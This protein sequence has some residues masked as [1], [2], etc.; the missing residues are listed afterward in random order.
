M[1]KMKTYEARNGE[2]LAH[3]LGLTPQHAAEWEVQLSLLRKLREIIS[4]KK[5]THSQVA[6][7]CGTS[8]RKIA[9]ILNGNLDDVSTD[10]LIRIVSSLG[11]E[12]SISISRS[13]LAA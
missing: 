8:Q 3:I 11:Y 6:K 4:K 7:L 2:E 5:M 10:L 13:K 9:A 12:V 1:T